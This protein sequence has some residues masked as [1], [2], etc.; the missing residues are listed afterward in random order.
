MKMKLTDKPSSRPIPPFALFI[1]ALALATA[2]LPAYAEDIAVPDLESRIKNT[3]N[4]VPDSALPPAKAPSPSVLPVPET[5]PAVPVTVAPA[6]IP[7]GPVPAPVAPIEPP[8]AEKPPFMSGFLNLGAGS[9]SALFGTVSLTRQAGD[10]P[11]F[12]LDFE[13]TTADGY[14]RE[15]FGTGF[16]DRKTVLAVRLFDDSVNVG[17][18]ASVTLG[19]RTDGFQGTSDALSLTHREVSWSAGLRSLPLPLADTYAS[20]DFEGSVFSA[21]ADMSGTSASN[22]A[23]FDAY[24]G[25]YLSP[26]LALGYAIGSF[27]AEL[28]GRYGYETVADAGQLNDGRAGLELKYTR[29]GTRMAADVSA[30]ADSSDGLVA[31]FHISLSRESADSLLRSVKVSGGLDTKRVSPWQLSAAEPFAAL[32]DNSV[33]A[34][35]WYGSADLTVAPSPALSLSGGAEYR[36]T[37]F[38]RGTLVTYDRLNPVDSRIPLLRVD[39]E[40]LAATAALVWTGTGMEASARYSGEWLDRLYRETL[41]TLDAGIT[42]F[43]TGADRIWEAGA[44]SVFAL[45]S[46]VLPAVN[47]TGTVHPIRKLSLTLALNDCLSIVSGKNRTRNGLY[48]ERSGELLLSARIDF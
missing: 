31:P 7:T 35:D 3:G 17:R 23:P 33:Y 13:H 42:V 12:G 41:H 32:T 36:T 27:S 15:K 5:P 14:G 40:S 34:S 11:G 47:L 1:A 48:L 10:L 9:P 19:D 38:G 37:A 26:R 6:A 43:D 39:R 8:A 28:F 30:F 2:A 16:F 25:Y 29:W 46:A 44:D 24:N 22:P 21:F 4:A 45:D 18:F 20:V